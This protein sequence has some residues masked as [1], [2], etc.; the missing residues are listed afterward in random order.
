MHFSSISGA[1]LRLLLHT[2]TIR[3]WLFIKLGSVA[4]S[5]IID[6]IWQN[7]GI[8]QYLPHFCLFCLTIFLSWNGLSILVAKLSEIKVS[9]L[10]KDVALVAKILIHIKPSNDKENSNNIFVWMRF[11]DSLVHKSIYIWYVSNSNYS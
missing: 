2:L 1:F 6:F 5:L 3:A 11:F 7:K 9:T 8:T 10:S 4:E